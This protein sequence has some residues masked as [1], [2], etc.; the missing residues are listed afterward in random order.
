MGEDFTIH[1][2]KD[3]VSLYVTADMVGHRPGGLTYCRDAIVA[4]RNSCDNSRG[5]EI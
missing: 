2:G 5:G 1:D 3:F 4:T